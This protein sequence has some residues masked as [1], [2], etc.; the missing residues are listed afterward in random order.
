MTKCIRHLGGWLA[1]AAWWLVTGGWAVHAAESVWIEAEHLDGIRGYCWPMGRP[2]MK[3]TA[4]HWGLSG[5]GWAAEW[6]MGGESGFLSIA[7]GADDDRAVA[8]KTIEVPV[9]GT[10]A[11]WVR[12]GDWREATERFQIELEQHG[13]PPW[14]GRYGERP[15]VDEDNEMKLYWGWVFTWDKREAALKKGPAR[16]S[17]RSTTKEPVPRQVDVIVLTT[18][19]ALSA[20]DQGAAAQRHAWAVLEGYRGG[21]PRGTRAAGPQP[22]GLRAAA[23]VEAAHVSR[24]GVPVPMEHARQSGRQLAGRQARSRAGALPR[25]RR[26]NAQAI[27]TEICRAGRRSDLLRSADRAHLPRRRPGGVRH[28]RQDRR[29]AGDSAGSWPGGSTSTP[30]ARGP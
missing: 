7:T 19:T 3:K 4:G 26:R 21:V 30:T 5:P 25:R 24:Q 9:D 27:R 14:I 1:L 18:D 23:L 20:E 6:N 11:V 12:Y 15:M 13:A 22:A 10:Y 17:L 29:G 16:L 28:R 8:T 2:E